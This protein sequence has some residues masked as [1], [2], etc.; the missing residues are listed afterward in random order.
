MPTI[1]K[2]FLLILLATFAG[3]TG[4]LVAAHEIQARRIPDALRRQAD[5]AVAEGNGDNAI[6][7]LRQFL[8][9]RPD[10]VDA[11]VELA[12]RLHARGSKR[13]LSFLYDTILRADPTR[14]ATRKLAVSHALAT[15]RYTDAAEHAEKLIEADPADGTAWRQLADARAALHRTDDAAAAYER[16]IALTPDDPSAF[17]EFVE[18][19]WAEGTN[20]AAAKALADRFAN[21]FPNRAEPYVLR[22]RM[23]MAESEAARPEIKADLDRAL[24][25][26][27][28]HA[29]A[30]VY[31]ADWLQRA[32]ETSAARDVLAKGTAEHKADVRFYRRLSWLDLHRGNM[33]LAVATLEAGLTNVTAGSDE[34]LIPLGDL[35][36]QLG[37]TKRADAIVAT[38]AAKKGAMP[39][40]QANY[41][42][43]RLAMRADDWAKALAL[44]TG[45]RTETVALPGLATQTNLLLAIAHRRTGHAAAERE[46]LQL[47][48]NR[49]PNH[50]P[51]RVALGQSYLAAGDVGAAIREYDAAVASPY[52]TGDTAVMAVRI[53]AARLRSL[54]LARPQDWAELD[55]LAA[56]T[57]AKFGPQSAEPVM[58]RAELI[59]RRGEPGRAAAYLR[60]EIAKRPGD[61]K[62]WCAVA[63]WTGAALGVGAG[64]AVCDEATTVTGDGPDVRVARANLMARDPLHA[65]PFDALDR[66]IDG[67]VDADQSR[68]LV[69]LVDAADRAGDA[70][71]VVRFSRRLA[72]RRASDSLAWLALF[73][74]ARAANDDATAAFARG[75]IVSREGAAGPNAVLCDAI[76]A[77]ADAAA[78][79]TDRLVSA[80]GP[81]PTRPD[82][83]VALATCRARAGNATAADEL[84]ERALV[85]D[86]TGFDATRAAL[87]HYTTTRNEPATRSLIGR[88]VTDPRWA[89]DPLRR[90]VVDALTRAKADGTTLRGEVDRVSRAEANRLTWL[91][92]C[93]RAIGAT[94]RA[95]AAYA[96][97]CDLPTATPDDFLRYAVAADRAAV[98][99]KAE[100]TLT[101]PAY[102]AA[103]AALTSSEK[104]NG[105]SATMTNPDDRVAFAR[106]RVQFETARGNLT[107]ATKALADLAAEPRLPP[108]DAA[109][110]NRTRALLLASKGTSE[111]RRTA[112]KLL[113]D[114]A[115]TA[116]T[117]DEK[118]AAAATLVSL[119]RHL[120]GDDRTRVLTRATELLTGSVVNRDPFL[121]F[122]VYR[123]LGDPAS[124]EKARTLLND[125]LKSEPTNGDYLVAGLDELTE[126][127]AFDAAKP[128]AE[129][130][131]QHH[132]ADSRAVAS[133]ARYECAAGRPGAAVPLVE[134]Y[135]RV[136]DRTPAERA[137]RLGRAADLL[138][139]L[140]RRPAVKTAPAGKALADAAVAYYANLLPGRVEALS[141]AAGLLAAT[142]RT[143]EA[144]AFVDRH[145]A[146][147]PA[148]AKA[149]AGVSILRAGDTTPFAVNAARTWLDAAKAED[150]EATAVLLTEGEFFTHAG[151]AAAAERA[152]QAVLDRDPNHGIALNNLA[153]V[154]APRADQAKRAMDLIDRA[155][156]ETGLTPE[157]L[158]TRARVRIASKQTDLAE[159]DL[160]AALT[161]EKTPLRYFHLAMAKNG[162]TPP[163]PDEAKRAFRSAVD[164]GL[165]APMIHPADLST[166]RAF[167]AGG[168]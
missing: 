125:L 66:Q 131:R 61:V 129:L 146:S 26:T 42:R 85:I 6:R 64:L 15:A 20:P 155:A 55:R 38:L 4:V 2:R 44:L 3:L 137:T 58:L 108:A 89:G 27:P 136:A 7:Y 116:G 162:A 160:L 120:D 21:A 46:C 98:M 110:A 51:A 153:W 30:L 54:G 167:L 74:K 78:G 67:W 90:V 8:E 14:T 117:A 59:G 13:E 57:A 139:D 43:A 147:L 102:F 86:P 25:L 73:E 11:R 101:K 124:R 142:G 23:A 5:R 152:F 107:A 156:K 122:Q 17:R 123:A 65:Y 49:D 118:R 121:L 148:R 88:L 12:D 154:L 9:F 165:D 100:K 60:Q 32:G 113:L 1:N 103:A 24:A 135:V 37:E 48:L 151:D 19:R 53:K 128:F 115:P 71:A 157:L 104:A 92:D 41:L 77:P 106:A 150:P 33:P 141:A 158:D 50:V 144:F 145:G 75:Q 159:K 99:A 111:D 63:E 140:A 31:S 69:G 18:W 76:A 119:H 114:A 81:A 127:K 132:P 47:V 166:Y 28:N 36:V 130:L 161:Q 134:G 149:A 72:A 112:A 34:L 68:L 10:D 168:N 52:S 105:W 91:G 96:A 35:L 109:W 87:V 82:V 22:A 138:D 97:A 45:L 95:V 126:S 29:D 70:D 83:C 94:S 39:Q 16:A 143:A 40:V 164:R 80:F 56:A 133:L 93:D 79:L 84:F 62:L 163:N